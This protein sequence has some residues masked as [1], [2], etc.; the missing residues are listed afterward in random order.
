MRGSDDNLSVEQAFADQNGV[1]FAG[2][3]FRFLEAVGVTFAVTEFKRVDSNLRRGDLFV[4]AFVEQGFQPRVGIHFVVM[5]AAGED[6]L[7]VLQ[8]FSIR[9]LATATT[10]APEVVWRFPTGGQQLADLGSDDVVDPVQARAPRS[11]SMKT[12]HP[13]RHQTGCDC[14][15]RM[16]QIH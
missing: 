3:G 4:F 8:R 15:H 9:H 12:E 13:A 5:T 10:R 7:V 2:L 14:G 6:K 11:W 16:T 1:R